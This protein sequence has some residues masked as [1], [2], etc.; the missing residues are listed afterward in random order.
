[1]PR[2][3]TIPPVKDAS[4]ETRI[5]G[6]ARQL[7]VQ[8]GFAETTMRDIAMAADCNVALVNYYFRSKQDLFAAI[9]IEHLRGFMQGL[10]GVVNDASTTLDEK[11]ERFADAYITMLQA[12]PDVPLF[13]LS[14]MRRDPS[15]LVRQIGV[16]PILM[17]SVLM[18]QIRMAGG[19]RSVEPIHLFM[20]LMALTVFP[21]IGKPMLK[22][23]SGT[24]DATFAAL[25]EQR[26]SLI[27]RWMS[28]MIDTKG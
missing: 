21:F 12:N 18:R 9:M 20:N 15:A 19:R 26:R 24:D 2:S 25:M 5:K 27:P 22:A 28:S 14:E 23:A 3:T 6:A 11:L 1:M 10:L 8:K 4:T 13:I 7:F 17:D 16:I